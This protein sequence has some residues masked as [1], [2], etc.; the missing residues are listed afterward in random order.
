MLQ[1]VN[2]CHITLSIA[3]DETE[4]SSLCFMFFI[5]FICLQTLLNQGRQKVI[6]ATNALKT[7]PREPLEDTIGKVVSV[8]NSS[9]FVKRS[10]F[11]EVTILSLECNIGGL[12][13]RSTC[14]S[15]PLSPQWKEN[16]S[17]TESQVQSMALGRQATVELEIKR[18]EAVYRDVLNR[19]QTVRSALFMSHS[20]C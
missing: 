3:H 4:K 9:L 17:L 13:L 15:C 7:L 6:E 11:N 16:P 19:Q 2:T 20:S 10:A 14:V 12:W 5:S 8:K 1:I 18:R